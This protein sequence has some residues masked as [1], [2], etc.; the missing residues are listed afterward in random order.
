MN[1]P[2]QYRRIGEDDRAIVKN[3]IEKIFPLRECAR[4]IHV[5]H[6]EIAC[7]AA[8]TFAESFNKCMPE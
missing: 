5:A 2:C 4:D 1:D 3:S 8:V 7:D 6:L